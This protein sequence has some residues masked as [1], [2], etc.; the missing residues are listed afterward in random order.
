MLRGLPPGFKKQG[1]YYVV[2]KKYLSSLEK[3]KTERPSPP[4]HA[5]D[6][7]YVLLENNDNDWVSVPDINGVFHWKRLKSM[8]ECK[9][10]E[11]YYTQYSDLNKKYSIDKTIETLKKASKELARIN[12]FIIQ[13]LNWKYTTMFVDD[14]WNYAEEKL[15]SRF[16][17][18]GEENVSYMFYRNKDKFFAEI[19]GELNLQY[20]IRK[21]AKK[22]TFE[23]LKKHFG[24]KIII[25]K[26]DKK[27]IIIRIN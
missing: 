17:K 4:Y 27:V 13:D 16:D 1:K 19:E 11:E 22:E 25:P 7:K 8:D 5:G 23:I 12:V 18:F 24:N 10:A 6:L 3:I 26:T 21:P 15:K 14:A 20:R 9:T 2:H